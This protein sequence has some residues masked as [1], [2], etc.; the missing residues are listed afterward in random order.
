VVWEA[1]RSLS[2]KLVSL[3]LKPFHVKKLK[4][5]CEAVSTRAENILSSSLNTPGPVSRLGSEELTTMTIPSHSTTV[6]KSLS[7]NDSECDGEE[8]ED[9]SDNDL[10]VLGEQ[11]GTPQ[12]T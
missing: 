6:V 1:C 3:G 7:D 5:W 8:E 12:L 4:R 9:T 10:E 2:L 11:S